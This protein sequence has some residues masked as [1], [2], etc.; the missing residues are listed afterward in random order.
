MTN[1]FRVTTSLNYSLAV[2]GA[3]FERFGLQAVSYADVRVFIGTA[4]P[5][6][7]TE[8]YILLSGSGTREL[9]AGLATTDKVYVRSGGGS[10]TAVRGFRESRA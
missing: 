9:T 10:T 1:T 8:D 7:D 6:E 2:D 3:T 4:P 5:A